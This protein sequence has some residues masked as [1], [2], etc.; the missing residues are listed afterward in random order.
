M[1]VVRLVS[2]LRSSARGLRGDLQREAARLDE[3][4]ERARSPASVRRVSRARDRSRSRSPPLRRG[5]GRVFDPSARLPTYPGPQRR[6][7]FASNQ[8]GL[9]RRQPPPP[10]VAPE[11]GQ[12]KDLLVGL[13]EGLAEVKTAQAEAKRPPLSKP[14]FAAVDSLLPGLGADPGKLEVFRRCLRIADSLLDTD[15]VVAASLSGL[16]QQAQLHP[17]HT[18]SQLLG[19]VDFG[20]PVA[21]G[22]SLLQP[23]AAGGLGSSGLS[24][25]RRSAASSGTF[26]RSHCYR[27][28]RNDHNRSLDCTASTFKSGEPIPAGQKARFAPA[29]WKAQFGFDSRGYTVRSSRPQQNGD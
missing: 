20:L 18:D 23:V 1:G 5:S 19:A 12:I 6:V 13:A 9:S 17:Q 28:G 11:L 2:R 10:A 29:E 7:S 4:D 3:R 25:S 24:L 15:E 26:V 14:L 8:P 27:C 22:A 21:R 16:W